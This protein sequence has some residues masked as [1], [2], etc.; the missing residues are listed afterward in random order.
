MSN[1]SARPGL[2]ELLLSMGTAGLR[3]AGMDASEASA[4]NISLCIDGELHVQTRFPI[5]EDLDLPLHVPALAGRTILVTGSGRRLRDIQRDP[6]GNVG[7]VVINTD[8][9]S[10]V[11]EDQVERREVTF[12]AV[13][14]AQPP[15]L[16][17][18]SH[19]ARY[20]DQ[21]FLNARLIRWEPES[22][23]ALPDG[24][25]VLEFMV[26]GSAE[27][28]SANVA[29]LRDHTIVL[30]SKHGVMARSDSSATNCVDRIE[31]AETGAKY[32]LMNLQYGEQGEGLTIEELRRVKDTFAVRTTLV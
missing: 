24:V 9:A 1:D 32:E 31:Y 12:H 30:W 21:A 6:E 8:G 10:A 19:I 17:Y 16:T 3:V 15:L 29:A 23:V 25:A 14:H 26:P 20:R 4:G 27:L 2:D 13:A 28:M 7:A 5:A 11:H 22:I 18:L